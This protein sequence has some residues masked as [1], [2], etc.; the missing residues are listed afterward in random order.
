MQQ[1]FSLMMAVLAEIDAYQYNLDQSH[2]IR[3]RNGVVGVH[4]AEAMLFQNIHGR[5]ASQLFN[6]SF[7]NFREI[8]ISESRDMPAGSNGNEN[9]NFDLYPTSQDSDSGTNDTVLSSTKSK[10]SLPLTLSP[11]PSLRVPPSSGGSGLSSGIRPLPSAA[12]SLRAMQSKSSS[13]SRRAIVESGY[14]PLDWVA[15]KSNLKGQLEGAGLPPGLLHVTPSMLKEHNGR[16]GRD[17]WTSYQGKVYN[18]QPYIPYHPGGKREILRGAGE[19]S[20]KMFLEIHPWVNWDDILGE[21]L[22]GNLVPEGPVQIENCSSLSEDQRMLEDKVHD[23]PDLLERSKAECLGKEQ[24]GHVE[25]DKSS[26]EEFG[27]HFSIKRH[28]KLTQGKDI[29]GKYLDNSGNKVRSEG[30]AKKAAQWV[31]EWTTLTV[32]EVQSA[33]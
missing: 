12:S 21:R 11:P 16:E 22:V 6:N 9:D 25:N 2:H 10:T 4:S 27:R 20:D 15:L 30:D 23:H 26:N 7:F 24:E 33:I 17:A 28:E 29:P 19:R 13:S 5:S 32:E 31:L 3:I 18:I 14:S 1:Y 8:P